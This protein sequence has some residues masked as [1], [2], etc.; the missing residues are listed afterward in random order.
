M[1][2]LPGNNLLLFFLIF[3]MF[4]FEIQ[5]NKKSAYVSSIQMCVCFL[6]FLI[7]FPRCGRFFI[8]FRLQ[9]CPKANFVQNK[10][11]QKQQIHSTPC[12]KR[13]TLFLTKNTSIH[14]KTFCMFFLSTYSY[15]Q[16]LSY[17]F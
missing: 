1:P 12:S 14:L 7:L 15:N 4:I 5:Q 13:K 16:K 17:I 9:V 10:H 2:Q 11:F 3:K 8:I 6:T